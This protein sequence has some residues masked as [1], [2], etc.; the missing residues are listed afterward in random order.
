MEAPIISLD[1]HILPIN[2]WD[3]YIAERLDK[4]STGVMILPVGRWPREQLKGINDLDQRWGYI[5]G[6]IEV[7][8]YHL[9]IY[10]LCGLVAPEI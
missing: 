1:P 10:V 7:P 3:I 6:R 9:G 8:R 5:A 2:S 4:K